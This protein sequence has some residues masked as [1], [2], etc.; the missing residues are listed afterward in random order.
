MSP[1]DRDHGC[2]PPSA[3]VPLGQRKGASPRHHPSPVARKGQTSAHDRE[4]AAVRDDV[5]PRA[6]HQAVVVGFKPDVVIDRF[7]VP[8]SL[9][10]TMPPDPSSRPRRP[11]T[12]GMV[13]QLS[14]AIAGATVVALLVVGRLPGWH[15]ASPDRPGEQVAGATAVEPVAGEAPSART[16]PQLIVATAASGAVGEAIPL[17]ISLVDADNADTIVLNGLPAGSN[18][19]SGRPL[20][21]SAWRLSAVELGSAA[22]RPA[23]GFAGGADLTVELRRGSRTMDR[24]ALHV[25]WTR[26]PRS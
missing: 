7:R 13:L 9:E 11:S 2:E 18:I 16:S 19:T 25:D 24:R 8:R 14:G 15:A 26:S 17:A 20:G 3:Y 4:H 23:P 12:F 5:L 6:E 22:I 21:I 10:P 1:L